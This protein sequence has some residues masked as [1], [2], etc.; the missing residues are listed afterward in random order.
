MSKVLDEIKAVFF[1]LGFSIADGPELEDD[2]HNFTALNFPPE[3]PARD[4]QDTFYV[5]DKV[6][7][8]TQTSGVQIHVME[9]QKPPIRMIAPGV[10]YR[11]D[12]DTTHATMFQQLEGLV[13]DENISFAHLKAIFLMWA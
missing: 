10:V 2:F 6:V 9:N 1:R 7:L 12:S 8:R 5:K 3:H 13:V 11:V 4:M